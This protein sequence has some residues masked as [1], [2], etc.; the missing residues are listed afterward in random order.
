MVVLEMAYNEQIFKNML[1]I[2]EKYKDKEPFDLG[3]AFERSYPISAVIDMM[4][5]FAQEKLE[6]RQKEVEDWLLV[7][8]NLDVEKIIDLKE[9]FEN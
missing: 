3:N 2:L 9:A 8:T 4:V 5:E 7:N 6:E 1:T